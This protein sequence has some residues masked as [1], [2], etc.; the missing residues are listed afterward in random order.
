LL[1]DVSLGRDELE[2]LRLADLEGLSH[3]EVGEMMNVSRATAGRILAEARRKTAL[4]LVH[5][6]AIRVEGGVVETIDAHTG[7]RGRGGQ[8]RGGG[9]GRGQGSGFGRRGNSAAALRGR[10][11]RAHAL[12]RHETGK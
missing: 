7:G 3:E 8:G 6:H 1:E 11:R 2:A 4:A 9:R 5:G 10:L 12:G